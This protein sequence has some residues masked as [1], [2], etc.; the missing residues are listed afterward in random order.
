MTAAGRSSLR[1]GGRRRPA[2]VRLFDGSIQLV[3]ELYKALWQFGIDGIGG[4]RADE[5]AQLGAPHLAAE[6]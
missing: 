3:Q 1:L 4:E 5:A 6:L 2:G